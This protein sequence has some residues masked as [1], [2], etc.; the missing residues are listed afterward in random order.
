VKV[1]QDE[2]LERFLGAGLGGGFASWWVCGKLTVCGRK[3]RKGRGV[4]YN[5]PLG[6]VLYGVWCS[7]TT[8]VYLLSAVVTSLL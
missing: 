8:G 3:G 5:L 7:S 6:G 4:T 1:G 2:L